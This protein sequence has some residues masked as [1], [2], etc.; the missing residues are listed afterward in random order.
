MGMD[1]L[2]SVATS[3]VAFDLRTHAARAPGAP[4]ETR[5]LNKQP[6]RVIGFNPV[7]VGVLTGMKRIHSKKGAPDGCS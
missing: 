6:G 3:G 7:G 1:A 5:S 2:L 4:T